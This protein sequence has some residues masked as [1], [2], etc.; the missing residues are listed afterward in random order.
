MRNVVQAGNVV[1]LDEGNRAFE[2]LD[3]ARQSNWT[4]TL[5]FTQR[6]CGSAGACGRDVDAC[7][8]NDNRD[9]T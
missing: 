8:H 5:V 2:T 3:M 4:R 6:A 7:D 9:L 1:V